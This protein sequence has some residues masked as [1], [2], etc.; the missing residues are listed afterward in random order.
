MKDAIIA[1]LR[2]VLDN[3]D[4]EYK[5][6]Y[7]LS[8]CRKLLETYPPDPMPFALKLYCHWALHIDLDK[9]NTTLPFLR[10]VD[11]FAA[12]VLDGTDNSVEEHRML[13]EFIYLH[14]F[15]Q[16]FGQFL[17]TLD[18]PSAVCEDNSRWHQFLEYY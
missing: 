13:L 4:S 11:T 15:R 2:S 3:V 10:R 5:V 12:N 1:K 17:K 14:T 8:G 6:V 18:L 9:P 7:I 16:Q